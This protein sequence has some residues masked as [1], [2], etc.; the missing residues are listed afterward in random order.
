[1]GN[2]FKKES[3][4]EYED[5]EIS[6]GKAS[7]GGGIFMD[8][9]SPRFENVRIKENLAL[10]ENNLF[11]GTQARSG[12]TFLDGQGGGI[13][14]LDSRPQL[15]NLT[16]SNNFAEDQ[17]G[18]FFAE[19]GE[20][21][22]DE[23]VVENNESMEGGGGFSNSTEVNFMNSRLNNNSANSDGGGLFSTNG[24]LNFKNSEISN[25]SSGKDGGGVKTRESR[26]EFENVTIGGNTASQSGGGVKKVS[27]GPDSKF[28][29]VL[30]IGNS[31]GE[32]GGGL[33]SDS[34]NM[35]IA[36]SI[37][38]SNEGKEGGNV[39]KKSGNGR[40]KNVRIQGG[41]AIR[42]G[43]IYMENCSTEM[44]NT[45][46][47]GNVALN[48]SNF[49]GGGPPSNGSSFLEGQGGGMFNLD[50]RPQL[51]NL[52]ISGNFAEDSGGGMMNKDNSDADV[53]NTIVHNNQTGVIT[54]SL[55]SGIMNENSMPQ[56][57]NSIVQGSNG[58][59]G[60]NPN[61]G[62]D[63]G[64]NFD[65]NPQFSN[66]LNPSP[67]PSLGGN[68]RLGGNSAAI[69][70]GNTDDVP[71]DV[72]T[73]IVG[74]NRR[75][76]GGV[77]IGA[78]ERQ[79]CLFDETNTI[80]VNSNR[81]DSI[82]DGTSWATAFNLLFDALFYAADC[83]ST[84][85]IYIAEGTY[86]PTDDPTDRHT[87]VILRDN[88]NIFG[89][90]P[91]TGN[92]TLDDR[93][94]RNHETILSGDINFSGNLEGN[95]FSVVAAYGTDTT[96]SL[97]GV[98]IRDGNANGS[99]G[100][101][102]SPVRTGAGIYLANSGPRLNDIRLES[103]NAD[104]GAGIALVGESSPEIDRIE[105]VN[106]TAQLMGGGLADYTSGSDSVLFSNMLFHGNTAL[107]GGG[108]IFLE[109]SRKST[110]ANLTLTENNSELGGGA[111][112]NNNSN[113]HLINSILWNNSSEIVNGDSLLD[114][115]FSIVAQDD[116]F[117]PGLGNLNVNPNFEDPGNKDFT[118][119]DCSPAINAGDGTGLP[120]FDLLGNVRPANANFD[121]GSYEFQSTPG[122]ICCPEGNVVF[123]NQN[124]VGFNNGSNWFNA[125]TD[126]Q[127]ALSLDCEN[128][129]EIWVAQGTYFPD[130][131]TQSRDSSFVLRNGIRLIGGFIGTE[132]EVSQRNWES[133]TTILSG[134][135]NQSDSLDGNSYSII[136]AI[137]TDLTAG[138]DGFL[139][140]MG[141]A[142][143]IGADS[144]SSRSGAGLYVFQ[145]S[146]SVE[147]CRFEDNHAAF[148]G[149]GIFH[150]HSESEI[151]NTVF[152]GNKAGEFG[153]A[154]SN[155]FHSS[156]SILECTF[157]ENE[158]EEGGAISNQFH[159][160]P[161]ITGCDFS[162]NDAL[163][164]G[165]IF[166][167]EHSSPGINRSTFRANVALEYGGA[168][169]SQ[170]SSSP[171]IRNSL[172][173]GNA[174]EYGGALAIWE[175]SSPSIEGVTISGNL[176]TEAGGGIFNGDG[177]NPIIRNSI[178]WNNLAQNSLEPIESSIKNMMLGNPEFFFSLIQYSGGSGLSWES[179]IGVDGG[180][181][182]DVDPEF[183]SVV[184][185]SIAPT[186][187]GNFLLTS[188][189]PAINA[190]DTALVSEDGILDLAGNPRVNNDTIDIGSYEYF[191]PDC[192]LE[193][194]EGSVVYVVEGGS[195]AE[196]GANWSNAIG[197]LQNALE[198]ACKCL[199]I[200]EV[201]VA[202]GTYYPDNGRLIASGD[203]NAS[204]QLCNEVALL[205]GF[206]PGDTS[207]AQ[208][209]WVTNESILSGDINILNNPDDNSFTVV[210]A[211]NTDSTAVIDGFTISGGR[212][213]GTGGPATPDQSGAGVY[214]SNGSPTIINCHITENYADQNGGGIYL[215]NN[216]SPQITNS[217]FHNNIADNGGGAYTF[218]GAAPVFN[219]CIFSE[220]TALFG[221]GMGNLD[222]SPTVYNSRFS[223]N[224]AT[225][226][227]G[228]VRNYSSTAVF[229]NCLFAGNGAINGA[230]I[231]NAS[232]S[233][234]QLINSTIV[235]NTATNLGGGLQNMDNSI[236]TLSNSIV[237]GN[238]AIINGNQFQVDGGTTS[239][240]FSAFR[241]EMGDVFGSL[242][243]G[244]GNIT[245]DPLF[246]DEANSDF[247]LQAC[248]PALDIGSNE[249]F[250][251]SGSTD[252]EGNPRFVN[253]TGSVTDLIDLGAFEFQ[254]TAVM[255]EINCNSMELFLDEAGEVSVL[256]NELYNK[257][258]SCGDFTLLSDSVSS[259]Q[260]TC[261]DLGEIPFFIQVRDDVSL[262]EDQC[263][264]LLTVSDTLAPVLTCPVSD[265][266]YVGPMCNVINKNYGSL[267]DIETNC[268]VSITQI[269]FW[270]Q[271]LA[272]G[273]Y[274]QTVTAVDVAGNIG[275]CN[276]SLFVLDT[277]SPIIECPEDQML[278]VDENCTAET[279]D[280]S[281]GAIVSDNCGI[282]SVEQLPAAGMVLTVG[283]S[284]I[285]TL[286]ATDMSGNTSSCN[287]LVVVVDTIEPMLNCLETEVV[288]FV[289]ES[290][291]AL[292][293]DIRHLAVP[294]DNCIGSFEISQ[295]EDFDLMLEGGQQIEVTINVAAET[296]WSA[297][298]LVNVISID[299][300]AP[301]F[302]CDS[303]SVILYV[304]ESCETSMPDFFGKVEVDD[305]CL[306]SSEFVFEQSILPG[307]ALLAGS[308]IEVELTL[309]E[310]GGW[311][312]SC[313]FELMV[314]DTTA[315]EIQCIDSTIVLTVGE[316]CSIPIGDWTFLADAVDNC[317][318]EGVFSVTQSVSS[319][320][321]L[322]AE[323]EITL[324]LLVS[325]ASGWTD[326]CQVLIAAVNLSE[327]IWL[328][329]L[330]ENESL[331]CG[332]AFEPI[333]L[334]TADF[335]DT[336]TVFPQID[337]L[338]GCM[339]LE[340]LTV[341]WSFGVLEH[342]QIVTFSDEIAPEWLS[343]LPQD[344]TVDCSDVPLPE[345]LEAIDNC[346]EV[347]V[348]FVEE[349]LPGNSASEYYLNR[350]WIASDDC[351]NSISHTQVITVTDAIPPT[352][353]CP[354]TQF[355]DAGG[356]CSITLP[357]FTAL[358]V[359]EDN[360]SSEEDLNINQIPT[361]GLTL[362][363]DEISIFMTVFDQAGN[364]SNCSFNLVVSNF[365]EDVSLSCPDSL[366]LNAI[367]GFCEAMVSLSATF[368]E[369]CD[370]VEVVNDFSLNGANADGIYPLGITQVEFNLFQN[371]DS[372]L[373]CVTVVSVLD[374]QVPEIS[375]PEDITL[376]VDPGSC[377]VFDPE[378]G[379]AEVELACAGFE[380]SS[381]APLEFETGF[382]TVVYTVLAEN[383]Q[384][385]SCE[386]TISVEDNQPPSIQCPE[387]EEVI[388]ES[389][390]CE[391]VGYQ[392][393]DA[394]ATSFCGSVEV[395]NNAIEVFPIGITTIIQIASDINGQESSCTHTVSVAAAEESS[396]LCPEDIQLVL[397]GGDCTVEDL[398]LGDAVVTGTCESFS[399]ENNAPEVFEI[400]ETTVTYL[401]LS[402][403]GTEL[404]CNQTVSLINT[405]SPEISCPSNLFV[406]T[407]EGF[408]FAS[409]IDPG[410]PIV[411]HSCYEVSWS[412]ELPAQFSVGITIV[413]YI[414]TAE[415]DS[416]AVCQSTVE[417]VDIESPTIECPLDVTVEIPNGE[418]E[419]ALTID[420]ATGSDNCG[421]L[422]IEN[423][424]NG[425]ENASGIYPL[426]L[427]TVV[428]TVEDINGNQNSC[429]TQ[430]LVFEEGAPPVTVEISGNFASWAGVNINNVELQVTGDD[431]GNYF[432]NPSGDYLFDVIQ[433]SNVIVTP[434]KD[435]NW[436]DGVSVTDLVLIQRHIL[437]IELLSNPYK[438]IAAD[439]SGSGSISTFDLV[440]LQ[441][442][443]I[444]ILDE[445]SSN[446]PWLFVPGSYSFNN[447][448]NPL[449]ESWPQIKAYQGINANLTNEDWVSMKVGDVSGD[450]G[451]SGQRVLTEGVEFALQVEKGQDGKYEL[452]VSTI[453]DEFLTG[454]QLEFEYNNYEAIFDRVDYSNNSILADSDIMTFRD[455]DLDI[456]RMVWFN[457][458][459]ANFK[460]GEE[461]F[462]FVFS[463]LKKGADVNSLIKPVLR[464]SKW[465]PYLSS[466]GEPDR[467]FRAMWVD[468]PEERPFVLYQ[469]RPNP[470]GNATDIRFEL[471]EDGD[472]HIE[473]LNSA[474]QLL[475][476]NTVSGRQGLNVYQLQLE[477]TGAGIFYLRVTAGRDFGVKKMVRF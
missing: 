269:P 359:V 373:S 66:P 168:L 340:Q 177:G 433:G 394:I 346:S 308:H 182:L 259:Y 185:P 227:G 297:F 382:H 474:G 240:D 74:N 408:C 224:T 375:C 409:G 353:T 194:P 145:G 305:N 456:V 29:R 262:R 55:E 172:F 133:N 272:P 273:Q 339:G 186:L 443:I 283:D 148:S 63:N 48:E 319:E 411:S 282:M 155:F 130:R 372:V 287:F 419:V 131:G 398:L 422:G 275:T 301:V 376:Q 58:S 19:E 241:N 254:S 134:D 67:D 295:S 418:T 111:I 404:S 70:S 105:F 307:T 164:G 435:M 108:G 214:C 453:D 395:S 160:S 147:N 437:G 356:M 143:G 16:I 310:S 332:N 163:N 203:R 104:F 436:L 341:Y 288:R 221:G 159:S 385:A 380:I 47:T 335:C 149:G 125:F 123:V 326:S 210:V 225:E 206:T 454:F 472:V 207:L 455:W 110:L 124:A 464:G 396:I 141:N 331:E 234:L 344:I 397:S 255:P 60:W 357:D 390:E 202:S 64:N 26:I 217:I 115:T 140:T 266:V 139:I 355:V 219:N 213:N 363:V 379:Q 27:P 166:N 174:A 183:V 365:G 463:D 57:N 461:V 279:E 442:L 193:C 121:L 280:Y 220:N 352:S 383:G 38:A 299:T 239:L 23:S 309:S 197:S 68:F 473:I 292:L 475:H 303:S 465:Q 434:K 446:E 285:T 462:R 387:N 6:K 277:N 374:I 399:I 388:L 150:F 135:I 451:L 82:G 12:A 112:Q 414:A 333:S 471:P 370:G 2:I 169:M 44:V 119:K 368:T 39:Y 173:S 188:C 329:E 85:F 79:P 251:Y 25:N 342:T 191:G 316:N 304:D 330:P 391:L 468:A 195:G 406:N 229:V 432:T 107:M 31:A 117:Y 136:T 248:S 165:A 263:S 231:Q 337:S 457:G 389:G 314:T 35:Q 100:F 209:N 83:D 377:A 102:L 65:F 334:I 371:G 257:L 450:A 95:S 402:N 17:G 393:E 96:A 350:Q 180:G 116:G 246:V 362:V 33:S 417:V 77:D 30:V 7:Q 367:P 13:F 86:F 290:C 328:T 91:G 187:D 271:V 249:L 270:G 103:N 452:V 448:E 401:A 427:T 336:L 324:T 99:N 170:N 157:N 302:S 56:F 154:I 258:D 212:S 238:T 92:P 1:G 161:L 137:D 467:Y 392:V 211:S 265:T 89:G 349:F 413:E 236:S 261:S 381:N 204:F 84:F 323:E 420:P 51:I 181:N 53:R 431:P 24:D 162:E 28:E 235:G 196:S 52:T 268:P 424:F 32:K 366:L 144:S 184:N 69:D 138:I 470:F 351:N 106:N 291:T 320:F 345:S 223:N 127:D 49:N 11:G 5:V 296:G 415:N 447:P 313:T 400:G 440:V 445:I 76:E 50:S 3:T 199:N 9:G 327:Y 176:A 306:P 274:T 22:F 253:S 72:E 429:Q 364:S 343:P 216:S 171:D 167:N 243:I 405:D 444:G 78:Y 54:D 146:I 156:P 318:E 430:V 469:N 34:S 459:G 250:A 426:G 416:T 59:D 441:M 120:T 228:G 276:F 114:V 20:M 237:W 62:Q 222:A 477:G 360:C 198:I 361:P 439:V 242:D 421:L 178:I 18:G 412:Y 315:P 354:P 81:S 264:G 311:S 46:F 260:F 42:G 93:D 205:G 215:V 208:R 347:E 36:N 321:E 466:I 73:D 369:D 87:S 289:N 80:Y 458:N 126:L 298:C 113:T 4:S 132:S 428:F 226:D 61:A 300:I 378:L 10:K 293:G 438:I 190:G 153:G 45:Q 75:S 278:F 189:S 256:I 158:A 252:L 101:L 200:E 232:N 175:E 247:N 245:S 358:V 118:L 15:I 122:T 386:Q 218:N 410:D 281:A 129:T 294:S 384:S 460:A 192:G 425:G 230:G 40:Y 21:E 476:Q 71:P 233:D 322:G 179:G 348:S 151:S 201:W 152:S 312:E 97:S 142:D 43:G 407:D 109:N 267:I 41:K 244:V 403:E 286:T 325:E 449:Q 37:F 88:L 128:V 98:V 317:L 94:W 423:D 284:V 14:G 90:F 338:F 8:K